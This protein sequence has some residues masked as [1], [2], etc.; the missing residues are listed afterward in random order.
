MRI[1]YDCIRYKI[2]KGVEFYVFFKLLI[3]GIPPQQYRLK[4]RIENAKQLLSMGHRCNEVA[5]MLGYPDSYTFSHQFK[6]IAGTTP[7]QYRKGHIL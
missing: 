3:Y 5:D 4:S 7:K 6:Q 1:I 2:A